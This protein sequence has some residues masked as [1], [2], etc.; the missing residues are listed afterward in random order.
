MNTDKNC[1]R[2]TLKNTDKKN[3]KKEKTDRITGFTGLCSSLRP[4]RLG[5]KVIS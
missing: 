5:G 2:L 3:G 1:H 4:S